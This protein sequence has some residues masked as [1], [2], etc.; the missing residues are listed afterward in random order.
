MNKQEL[1]EHILSYYLTSGDFN[2]IPKYHLDNYSQDDMEALI[3]EGLIETLSTREVVNPH[4]KGYDLKLTIEQHLVNA[5]ATDWTVCFY[6]TREA[7]VNE[8]TDAS[9]PYT[10]RLQKGCPQFEIVYFDIEVLERYINN[11]KYKIVDLG[12]K[13]SIYLQ[14]SYCSEDEEEYGEY[15]KEYGMAYKRGDKLIR[16]VAVF[17]RDLANVPKKTQMLWRSFEH[18]I[19]TDYYVARGF[20]TNAIEGAFVTEC[21]IFDAMLE[22]MGIINLQCE[23][24]GIPPLFNHVWMGDFGERPDGYGSILL[25]TLKNYYDFISVL[26]KLFVHNISIKAFQ[27]DAGVIRS[28]ERKDVDGKEKGSIAMFKEWLMKNVRASFD[29]AEVIIEPLKKIRKLRQ[30]PAHE[31]INNEYDV[32][33][34]EK[35]KELVV[36]TYEMLR[37]ILSLFKGHPLA[38]RIEIP[39]YLLTGENIVF[40]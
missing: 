9:K 17:V 27:K 8:T 37:A 13:G 31:M 39:E 1:L 38:A 25:P 5:K 4:I 15:I 33:V 18:T 30:T 35:Q 14:D 24:V 3:K 23:A 2:G 21:W 11:P 36:E 16:A 19:Q 34:Y 6:P 20:I 32:E 7:L 28:V 10:A 12:Y 22:G 26:E 40:Y 29:V